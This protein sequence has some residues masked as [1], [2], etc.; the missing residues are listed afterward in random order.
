MPLATIPAIDA[1]ACSGWTEQDVNLYNRLP[2]Y[3][4][5]MQV[6]RRKTWTTWS[7]FLGKKKWQPNMGSTM[8][9]VTKEPSPHLR[10]FA[11]PNPICDAPKK[12]V[13][14]VRERSVDEV[15]YRHRFESNVLSFC[16]SFRDFLTD[17][18]DAAG[19]DIME[20]EERFE[21]IFYR[22][23]ILHRSPFIWITN[24][25]PSAD[26]AG[27]L[28][29]APIGVGN[30]AGTDG[31]TTA[32]L[33]QAAA[34]I[35]PQGYLSFLQ[36]NK[37]LTVMENDIRAVPFRGSMLPKEDQGLADQFALV[38]ST[39]AFNQFTFDPYLQANKNCSLDVVNDRFRGSLF[40]RITCILE[41]MPLRMKADGTFVAPE[42]RE[43]N[44][45]A[46]NYGESIPNPVYVSLDDANGSPYEWAFLVGNS[47][48]DIIEVGPP[49][50]AF[51][52]NGMPKGF[53]KMFWNGEIQITKN[54]LIPCYDDAG[55]LF[56]ET[57][58]YGEYLKFISQ[59]TYGILSKQPRYI[60]PILFKRKRGQ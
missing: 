49:P 16:P 51:A 60:L 2:F 46:Y 30:A 15:V 7:R 45:N 3:L 59:V 42:V 20:K 38:C 6:D 21:D 48:Y 53:G 32:Y 28:K 1:N 36:L 35:G 33:Q 26:G 23:R 17:H 27:E 8:R 39:E 40:G 43:L 25:G 14:D 5:K 12:D 50:A 37:A 18:V 54:F 41:D 31:K 24:A 58:Q 55:N 9:A 44:P 11:Y 4:T 56:W 52:S 57:N 19:Q 13:M 34:Q 47:G 29:A 10:Q 22:G